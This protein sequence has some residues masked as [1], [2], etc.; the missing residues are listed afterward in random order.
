ML[1]AQAGVADVF[2]VLHK[3]NDAGQIRVDLIQQAKESIDIE[4]YIFGND[5]FTL[6][7]LSLLREANRRGVRVR[8]LLD[9]Q[10]GHIPEFIEALLITEG[11]EIKKYHPFRW[12]KLHWISRRLHDKLILVDRKHLVTGGRNIQN[13]YFG[14]N[15]HNFVDRDVYVTG[16]AVTEAQKYFNDRWFS[17]EVEPVNISFYTG[18]G[19]PADC[20]II[21]DRNLQDQCLKIKQRAALSPIRANAILEYHYKNLATQSLFKLNTGTN[22][23]SGQN[24]VSNVKF[25]HDPI[26]AKT[27]SRNM[28]D[29]I[30]ELLESAEK[31]ILIDSPYVVITE[32]MRDAFSRITARGVKIRMLTNSLASSDSAITQAAY[33]RY[34]DFLLSIGVELWEYRGP[35]TYHAKSFLIDDKIAIIGSYNLDPRSAHLNTEVAVAVDDPDAAAELKE[36]MDEHL[37]QAFKIGAD[38]MPVGEKTEHPGASK[39]K[40]AALRFYRLLIPLIESQL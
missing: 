12:T 39:K 14:L 23:S 34:K 29:Q 19:L 37:S 33:L 1:V 11:I 38:G 30:I 6:P 7:G 31:T 21:R 26:G 16:S 3:D 24:E 35:D 25:L 17:T 22:W 28:Q 8:L 36:S 13:S 27:R 9:A 32:K 2:R 20:K 15:T 4:Y 5:A 10:S 40:K 18:E